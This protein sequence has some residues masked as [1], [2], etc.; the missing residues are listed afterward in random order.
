MRIENSEWSGHRLNL[1][2]Y[3]GRRI[4]DPVLRDDIVQEA[5]VKFWAYQARPDI[6]VGNVAGLLRRI[7]LDLTRDHY[8]RAGRSRE[9]EL[10]E[11][12]ECQQPSIQQRLEDRQFLE[13]IAAVVKA[14]PRMRREVFF[15]RRLEGQASKEV[16][17]AMGITVG[18]VNTH[19]ARAVLEL[20][21]AIDKIEARGGIVRG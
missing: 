17:K 10:S 9:A 15:R 5:I 8:R 3:V 19:I 11:E 7:S 14:M 12:I 1:L 20:D 13:I 18:A 4:D 21:T 2:R 6:V 16:A